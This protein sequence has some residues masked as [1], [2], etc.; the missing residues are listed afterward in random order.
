MSHSFP[1]LLKKMSFLLLLACVYVTAEPFPPM[2][3]THLATPSV[4]APVLP[5]F[6]SSPGQSLIT[7]LLGTRQFCEG[8]ESDCG[9]GCCPDGFYCD[10]P[11]C[12]QNGEVCGGIP[13]GCPETGETPCGF[14]SCCRPDETCTDDLECVSGGG[15]GGGGG[16]GSPTTTKETT[17]KKTT[18]TT[19]KTTAT[20][21]TSD[22]AIGTPGGGTQISDDGNSETFTRP[23]TPTATVP[24]PPTGFSILASPT[25]GP[26]T[27]AGSAT[28]TTGT[29]FWFLTTILNTCTFFCLYWRV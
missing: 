6:L 9:D 14:D 1:H 25:S 29:N 7:G 13:S 23:I 15:G 28:T 21:T 10:P 26:S 20:T 4:L 12:C 2:N 3:T 19:H 11:G 24:T 27:S 16:G 22:F 18:T 8:G 5:Y 17:T